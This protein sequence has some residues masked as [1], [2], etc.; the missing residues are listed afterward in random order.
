MRVQSITRMR[1]GLGRLRKVT[2]PRSWPSRQ[3]NSE[4]TV[5]IDNQPTGTRET[6][7]ERRVKAL[8]LRKQGQSYRAIAA[9]LGI[10]ERTAHTDV[11]RA[12]R[13]LAA[14]EQASAA[15]Y[16]TM[17]LERLDTLT[18]EAARVLSATHPLVSGGKVLRDVTDDGPKLAAIDRL[19]RISESRRKL[20]G[21]DAPAKTALT[22]PDGTPAAYAELRTVV[23]TLLAPYPDL[24]LALAEQLAQLPE[25]SDDDQRA[26]S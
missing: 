6:A 26:D 19:L 9:Q 2:P 10:N 21:L 16:R 25:V 17:E 13:A 8:E 11:Q 3:R 14:L 1:L 18:V 22:N 4:A 20:L 15:E 5:S 7:A 24:R 23:L 12:L